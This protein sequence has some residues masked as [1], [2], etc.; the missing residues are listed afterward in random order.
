MQSLGSSF[1][2]NTF[3]QTFD[4]RC[5]AAKHRLV[6]IAVPAT[7]EHVS[8]AAPSSAIVNNAPD[9]KAIAETVQ[10]FITMMDS[11]K[12]NMVAVDQLHP[13][14]ADLLQSVNR[15]KLSG[16]NLMWRDNLRDWLIKLN[17]M[18]AHDELNQ[19]D[20]RQ[21]MFDLEKAHSSFY[22]TLSYTGGSTNAAP[23]PSAPFA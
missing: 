13:L 16:S 20:A 18:N 21:L 19:A 14:L 11:I 17:Q 6:E 22:Q 2:I 7:T 5:P 23:G 15:A 12:L 4:L 3:I 10:G 9:P 8:A 1:D